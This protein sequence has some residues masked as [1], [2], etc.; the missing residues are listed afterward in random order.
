MGLQGNIW[1]CHSERALKT[2]R[3]QRLTVIK[4]LLIVIPTPFS[5]VE[6]NEYQSFVSRMLEE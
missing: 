1:S 4:T 6:E 5:L 3:L 2:P